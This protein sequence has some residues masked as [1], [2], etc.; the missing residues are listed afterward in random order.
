[1][2]LG[3]QDGM[4]SLEYVPQF[5]QSPTNLLS[6]SAIPMGCQPSTPARPWWLDSPLSAT[7]Q[8]PLTAV[9]PSINGG[10]ITSLGP[11]TPLGIGTG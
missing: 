1:M 9:A 2:Q 5:L 3:G 10:N 7:A 11:S 4:N 8:S 6:G